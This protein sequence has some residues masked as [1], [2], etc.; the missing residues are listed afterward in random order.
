MNLSRYTG[1][2]FIVTIK[3]NLVSVNPS[4]V[5]LNFNC[6]LLYN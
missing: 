2:F 1:I 4:L 3:K 6:D 5:G